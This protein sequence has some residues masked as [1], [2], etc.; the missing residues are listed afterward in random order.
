MPR[1]IPLYLQW[2]AVGVMTL[3]S[4]CGGGGTITDSGGTT[5]PSTTLIKVDTVAYSEHCPNKTTVLPGVKVL[6][7][8]ADGSIQS[9]WTTDAS[10]HFELEKPSDVAHISLLFKDSKNTYQIQS[11]LSPSYLDLGVR[12]FVDELYKERCSCKTISVNWSDLKLSQ[13]EL[14]L[15]LHNAN[16]EPN[17]NVTGS[18]T[19]NYC[20][21]NSG[22]LGSLQLMLTPNNAG[23]SYVREV[24]LDAQANN[25]TLEL[26][27]ADMT[28]AGTVLSW[29]ANM[30]LNALIADSYSNGTSDWF[31]R[32]S[33]SSGEPLRYFPKS[34]AR[35]RV[36]A[37]AE[38]VMLEE[39]IVGSIGYVSG[40]SQTVQGSSANLL[41]PDHQSL[42]ANSFGSILD[43]WRNSHSTSYDFSAVTGVNQVML[44]QTSP[45]LR[46]LVY[47]APKA[48]VVDLL[49]PAGDAAALADD[50]FSWLSLD[51]Y[52]QGSGL[53]YSD[54]QKRQVALSRGAAV[55]T[56]AA[57]DATRYELIYWMNQ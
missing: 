28:P 23:Q 21:D 20:A 31:Y 30:P 41:L 35:Q 34:N 36:Q 24:D 4:G 26:K 3:L 14:S 40:A 42:M 38:P 45:K 1:N 37:Y 47:S 55:D 27:L 19:Q 9:Q 10:G 39:S 54:F 11:E 46:W 57:F 43:Q 44:I 12:R 13:P 53:S 29:T 52:G 17:T 16:I 48:S 33:V 25:S 22:R 2:S 50:Q 6:L 15:H 56:S 18:V 8:K 51:F 5:P 7:H 49:L 32:V